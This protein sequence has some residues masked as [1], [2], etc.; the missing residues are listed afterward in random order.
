MHQEQLG[1]KEI[2]IWSIPL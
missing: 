2:L 1:C